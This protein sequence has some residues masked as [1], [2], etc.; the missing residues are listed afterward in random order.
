MYQL[1]T[2][3]NIQLT[4]A[5]NPLITSF[6]PMNM[7]LSEPNEFSS[8][9]KKPFSKG[10]VPQITTTGLGES[11]NVKKLASMLNM[12]EDATNLE[13]RGTLSEPF[14]MN[15]F[16]SPVNSAAKSKSIRQKISNMKPMTPNQTASKEDNRQIYSQEYGKKGTNQSI[17]ESVS[18]QRGILAFLRT[19]ISLII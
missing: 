13:T 18:P 19:L 11:Q 1:N 4:D 14:N 15:S 6:S 17:R 8:S 5:T 10:S 3:A 2:T 7:M 9:I 16:H 12:R